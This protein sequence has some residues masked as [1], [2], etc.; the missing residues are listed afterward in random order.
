M[1]ERKTASALPA[2]RLAEADGNPSRQ[3]WTAPQLS[4]LATS[5]AELSSG[6]RADGVETFS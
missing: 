4:R 1:S 3:P 2:G 6:A 5:A